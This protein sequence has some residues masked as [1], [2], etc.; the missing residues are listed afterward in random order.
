MRAC[1]YN[2]LELGRHSPMMF[3]TMCMS[4][5]DMGNLFCMARTARPP[6]N[7]HDALLC[8]AAALPVNSF[9]MPINL[10]AQ[11]QWLLLLKSCWAPKLGFDEAFMSRK[12]AI[13]LD[14]LAASVMKHALSLSDTLLCYNSSLI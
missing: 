7:S 12:G 9:T 6:T 8:S 11:K 14:C 3:H 4:E 10:Y 2:P 1:I 5:R 13:K